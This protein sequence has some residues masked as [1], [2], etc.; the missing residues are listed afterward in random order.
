M[1]I[2]PAELALPENPSLFTRFRI[3][4]KALL[5]L[6]DHPE[7][8]VAGPVVN[9]SFDLDVYARLIEE[10]KQTEE[11]RRLLAERPSLQGPDLDLTELERLP[12]GT[13]GREFA[14]YFSANGIQPFHTIFEIRNDSDYI[15]KRYRETH[16]L[17]HVL[18]GFATDVPGEMRLQAFAQG[19]LGIKSAMVIIALS[20]PLMLFSQ[21]PAGFRFK[22]FFRDLR[23]ARRLGAASRSVLTFPFEQHWATPVEEVRALF[24][25]QDDS[26][27]ARAA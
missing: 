12:D 15:S 7:D 11:G 2:D 17:S 18:T 25:A 24:L 21:R 20:V 3:G 4:L 10:L 13:L 6:K 9:A 26:S 5:H 23:E 27:V 19:N 14:R 16:D 22:A 1:P 8:P